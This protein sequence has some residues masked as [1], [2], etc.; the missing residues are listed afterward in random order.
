MLRKYLAFLFYTLGFGVL[1]YALIHN[2]LSH[3]LRTS[4]LF[5]FS[6]VFIDRL[7]S[8]SSGPR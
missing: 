4:I 8:R 3:V 5:L 6:I 2:D 1:D 7:R